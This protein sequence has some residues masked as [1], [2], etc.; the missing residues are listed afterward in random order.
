MCSDKFNNPNGRQISRL[1]GINNW[2]TEIFLNCVWHCTRRIFSRSNKFYSNKSLKAKLCQ[3]KIIYNFR[4]KKINCLR[5]SRACTQSKLKQFTNKWLN[6]RNP[7]EHAWAWM[8]RRWNCLC[9]ERITQINC[10]FPAL[11]IACELEI[12]PRNIDKKRAS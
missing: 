9:Q 5:L 10:A 7:H 1:D 2:L 8:F 11:P 3:T 12:Q 4:S 6:K